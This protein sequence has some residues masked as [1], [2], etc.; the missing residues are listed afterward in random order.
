MS[1]RTLDDTELFGEHLSMASKLYI[2]LYQY[3]AF[4]DWLNL[5]TQLVYLSL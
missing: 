4:V 3:D 5:P 1:Y 2:Q